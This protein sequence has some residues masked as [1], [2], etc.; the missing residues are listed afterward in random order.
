M[1]TTAGNK[2]IGKSWADGSTICGF[3]LLSF[4]PGG[5]SNGEL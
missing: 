5:T 2:S 3:S 1:R 4:S